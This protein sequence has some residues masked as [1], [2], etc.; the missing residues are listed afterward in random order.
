MAGWLIALDVDGT[1]LR[2]DGTVSSRTVDCLAAARARGATL[3]L[4]TGRDWFAVEDLLA[5]LT[6]VDYALCV[7][8]IEVFTRTGEELY[9]ASLDVELAREVVRML[10][11][12]LPGVLIGAGFAGELVAEPGIA[13]AMPPGAGDAVVTVADVAEVI[14]PGVRDLVVSH[15]ELA[16][17]LDRFHALCVDAL[18]ID[19]IDVA[20]TGLPMI[21]IVPPGAGKH[22]GLAWLSSHLGIDPERVLAFGDGLNDVSMLRWAGIG[23]AMG[24]APELVRAA[25]DHVTGAS[26]EDGLAVWLE[27]HLSGEGAETPSPLSGRRGPRPWRR[28]WWPAPR[29]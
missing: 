1:L 26:D 14:G 16:Q 28:G 24:D 6:A 27:R 22:A 20:F 21:E 25:A 10:R 3:S 12:A 4:A 7:N 9:A 17:D 2:S 19:G 15:H 13:E 29:R 5:R 18:P 23:V 11:E 8:G